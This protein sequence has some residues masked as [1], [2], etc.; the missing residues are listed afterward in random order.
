MSNPCNLVTIAAVLGLAA[1]ARSV[2]APQANGGV[3]LAP[4]E[5]AAMGE[6]AFA[7][8][9]R[10]QACGPRM[11]EGASAGTSMDGRLAFLRTAT[12]AEINPSW[13]KSNIHPH[14][15]EKCVAR[16]KQLPCNVE[17]KNVTTIE[18]CNVKP[19]CG[20]PPEGTL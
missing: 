11:A 10:E 8:A 3:S 9:A 7:R 15:L 17:L 19:L 18:P 13:C 16:I 12:V 6:I 14:D 5:S 1:C 4:D 2:G 20:V